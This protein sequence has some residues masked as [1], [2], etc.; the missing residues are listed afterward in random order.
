MTNEERLQQVL[1]TEKQQRNLFFTIAGVLLLA[2]L[3]FGGF[4]GH[5]FYVQAAQRNADN[6]AAALSEALNA[7]SSSEASASADSSNPLDP[8]ILSLTSTHQMAS[9]LQT[10]LQAARTN[11]L[12]L[13]DEFHQEALKLEEERLA[14]ER[15]AML[16]EGYTKV[17]VSS[18]DLHTGNLIV[19]N[20][21]YEYVFPDTEDYLS[22]LYDQEGGNYYLS[23]FEIQ[24]TEPAASALHSMLGAYYDETLME[25]ILVLNGYRSPEESQALFDEDSDLNGTIHAEDYIMLPG[26]SEHHTGLATDLGN[27]ITGEFID[28]DDEVYNWLYE[29]AHEYGYILRYPQ[30]KKLQTGIAY[31]DWHFR[32]VGIPAATDIYRTDLCMEEWVEMIHAY[33]AMDPYT[34]SLEDGDYTL[35]YVPAGENET[36]IPVPENGEYQISGD[37][38]GGFIVIVPPQND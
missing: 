15:A 25:E 32:Y 30:G 13:S 22:L 2:L 35:F 3:A 1:K 26:H 29:H 8:E 6:R 11:A 21:D 10:Q 27:I 24:M 20:K 17:T 23:S 19:V 4:T 5:R 12:S 28:S 33:T 36:E 31:E 16:P 34:I 38:M 14:K 7:S 9:D 18:S 37:N